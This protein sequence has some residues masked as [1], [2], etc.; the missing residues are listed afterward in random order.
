MAA[1]GL[2]HAFQGTDGFATALLDLEHRADLVK[3]IG[4]DA[5]A[6]VYFY[7]SCDRK[8][9]HPSLQDDDGLLVDRFTCTQ[10]IPGVRQRRDFAELTAANELDLVAVSRDIRARYGSGLLDLFT[11]WRHCCLT[12]HGPTAAAC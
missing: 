10:F 12:G 4:T 5:V 8:A 7:A 9:S 1:A 3:A 2:C 6:M 11:R